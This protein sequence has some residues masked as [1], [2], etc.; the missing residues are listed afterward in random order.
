M[1]C[2]LSWTFDMK[3]RLTFL[4]TWS[5]FIGSTSNNPVSSTESA[6]SIA[7]KFHTF[8]EWKKKIRKKKKK[9]LGF[10]QVRACFHIQLIW[11]SKIIRNQGRV[12][13]IGEDETWHVCL[14][15]L[16]LTW[17]RNQQISSHTIG[18]NAKYMQKFPL[19]FWYN[20]RLNTAL[21]LAELYMATS[22]LQKLNIWQLWAL[23]I[24]R[25]HGRKNG[26]SN[27]SMFFSVV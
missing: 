5:S 21:A 24:L 20:S 14:T 15:V 9:R 25:Q 8:M 23:L 26:K 27:T 10:Y 16:N 11:K 4:P 22:E 6:A 13:S 12:E 19:Q 18:C 2:P 7:S 3:F 17:N 1:G